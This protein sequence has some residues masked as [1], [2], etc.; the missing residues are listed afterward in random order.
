MTPAQVVAALKAAG[1]TVAT[2][3]SL[4]AGLV[5]ATLTEVPGASAVVRGGLVVYATDLKAS[6]AGVDPALLAAHG[7][8]N[9]EVAAQ[10]AAGARARCGAD[11]GVGLTGVAGPDPQDGVAPGT[12]HIALVSA[13]G[14]R[15]EL[16]E[17]VG[18]REEVRSAAVAGVLALIGVDLGTLSE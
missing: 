14:E 1:E 6:L 16:I 15:R 2:A 12:V 17:V 8:V 5:T 9:A 11:I 13:R 7:A 4:T 10:L 3:E 18:G